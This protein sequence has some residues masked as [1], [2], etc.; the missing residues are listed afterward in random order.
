MIKS[1][2]KCKKHQPCFWTWFLMTPKTILVCII[3][4]GQCLYKFL[5]E[6]LLLTLLLLIVLTKISL[7]EVQNFLKCSLWRSTIA[8]NTEQSI[9]MLNTFWDMITFIKKIPAHL[10]LR[11]KELKWKLLCQK[12]LQNRI[13]SVQCAL[14]CGTDIALWRRHLD[15]RHNVLRTFSLRLSP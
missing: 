1:T 5:T 14:V 7:Y 6:W 9:W 4:N 8:T 3:S 10:D 11:F 2:K 12:I 13:L 15:T